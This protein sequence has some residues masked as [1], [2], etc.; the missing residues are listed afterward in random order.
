MPSQKQLQ[1]S[2][3][4]VGITVVVAGIVLAVLIV[5]MSGTGGLLTSKIVLK[6]YFFDAQGLRVGAPVRLS[7]VDIGNVS[8]I[9]IVRDN[10]LAPV[11]VTMKVSTKY[12]FN[13]RKDSK[14][15][16]S[17]A[18]VLGET[19][20]NI[21]SSKATGAEVG[22]GDVLAT[23]EEPGY[24]DVMRSTQNALQNMQALL[25]RTDRIIAY[26][27]SGQGSVGKAIYD[28]ALYN[29]LNSTIN[30]FQ[31]LVSE[32]S[33][34]Q[35]SIGKFI[36]SDDLYNKANATIDKIN[37]MIDDLNAGKGT[38]GKLLKD[39]SLYDTAQQTVANFKQL[40]DD[41]NAGKGAIGTLTKD[42]VFA[43]KLQNTMN[44]ISSITDRL[45]NG[46]G[47]AGKFLHDPSMYD[48]TNKLLTDS[49]DLV[50]A[51]RQNPKKYLTIHLKIF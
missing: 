4:K 13:L 39:P 18:G 3:L 15:L 14:T 42:Q 10:P 24:Q 6:S 46:E 35:G 25:A 23:S 33:Q 48:N 11:E 8:Q 32:V 20:I 51:I 41:I 21:D 47:S 36:M 44:R 49:Q 40:T 5:L 19:Y 1:W 22:N 34:G 29:R 16:L 17:T 27:E 37:V 45:D 43:A 38:A 9:V 50:K 30:D 12:K 7:G 31:K 28:P 2:Q 26:V